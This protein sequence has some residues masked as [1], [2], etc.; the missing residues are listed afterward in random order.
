MKPLWTFPLLLTLLLALGCGGDD[1]AADKKSS[2]AT[3]PDEGDQAAGGQQGMGPDGQGGGAPGG[4]GGMGPD[5]QGGGAPG[6]EDGF[7]GTPGGEGGFGGAPGGE[8]GGFGG[9]TQPQQPTFDPNLPAGKKQVWTKAK[10]ETAYKGK[11]AADLVKNF[12]KPAS[13][14]Q[15]RGYTAYI[16]DKMYV[17]DKNM[18]YSQVTFAVQPDSASPG[19]G[20]I[21]AIG[22]VPGSGTRIQPAGGQNGFPGQGGDPGGGGPPGGFPGG[23]YPGGAPPGGNR[24]K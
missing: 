13:W 1:E 2:D 9:A 15:Q 18:K 3:I 7:G 24:P 10:I 4:E 20:K 5:G 19:G 16:Y 12:G 6:G 23:G 17:K 14:K 21:I 22:L 11:S 8:G